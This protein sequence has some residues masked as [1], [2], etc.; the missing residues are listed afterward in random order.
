MVLAATVRRA[1]VRAHTPPRPILFDVTRSKK[2]SRHPN[3]ILLVVAVGLLVLG[4]TMASGEVTCGGN[5]MSPGDKCVSYES[6]EEQTYDD[7][8][9]AQRTAPLRFGGAAVIVAGVAVVIG[10]RRKPLPPD[11]ETTDPET[12]D[13][14]K[15]EPEKTDNG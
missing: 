14:E 8:R 2:V 9:Q 3:I 13:P 5:V 11:P 1:A 12:A 15:S 6:G 4:F 7:V 10:L